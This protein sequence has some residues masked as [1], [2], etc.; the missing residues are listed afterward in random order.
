MDF[1][2]MQIS[3][4][5]AKIPLP[6]DILMPRRPLSGPYKT[7]Y[8]L[9]DLA[10]NNT[11]WMRQ[12]QI[13]QLMEGSR[14]VLVMPSCLNSFYVNMYYGSDFL[15][16]ITQELISL[17]ENWLNL[18][19]SREARMIAGIGMGGYGAVSAALQAPG[20]FG[21]AFSID[22]LLDPGRFYEQP[23]PSLKME[24]LFGP[25]EYYERGN[26]RL[27]NAAAFYKRNPIYKGFS[28]ITLC[29]SRE[30]SFREEA[31][32]LHRSLTELGYETQLYTDCEDAVRLLAEK[33]RAM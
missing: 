10:G 7:L 30:D 24:D 12:T 25:K 23:L 32:N 6:L 4:D 16:Y 17:C 1:I 29:S 31:E 13:E 8:L 14:T 20:V 21:A 18:E 3:T 22:G 2:H 27:D 9:H 28:Q 5:T 15:D 33:A 26:N 19:S 11:Q